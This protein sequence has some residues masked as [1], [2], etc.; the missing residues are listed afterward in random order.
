LI[1]GVQKMVE[2][3]VE[4]FTSQALA[5]ATE[6]ILDSWDQEFDGLRMAYVT[7]ETLADNALA[8]VLGL[9]VKIGEVD[10]DG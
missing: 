9:P 6:A 5:A 8:A 1:G 2:R 3:C 7:A 4:E 10:E